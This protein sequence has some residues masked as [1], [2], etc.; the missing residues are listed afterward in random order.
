MKGSIAC[1]PFGPRAHGK[2]MQNR[3]IPPDRM[4]PAKR[5]LAYG[6][7]CIAAAC[8]APSDETN[9]DSPPE[10]P[11][12]V[13]AQAS[14]LGNP[15]ANRVSATPVNAAAAAGATV[16]APVT[17]TGTIAPGPSLATGSDLAWCQALEVMARNCQS[18][19]GAEPQFGAPMPLVS[20]ADL[21]AQS[22]LSDSE[23]VAQRVQERIHSDRNPMPPGGMPAEDL[24]LLDSWLQEGAPPAADLDCG[25]LSGGG[26]FDLEPPAPPEF[27]WPDDCEE[28][29]SLT[30]DV[31]NN[32]PGAYTVAPGAESHPQF[33]FDAPWGND[34]VQIVASRPI[35]DNAKVLHHWILFENGGFAGK[36]LLGWAP[37]KDG[38][39]GLPD[40]VGMYMPGGRSSL[41]L[42]M[43]YY[44]LGSRQ[45]EQ[46][47]S[48]VEVCITRTPRPE[49]A[50][51]V[52]LIGSATAPPGRVDN[53]SRCTVN[54]T[55]TDS[56]KLLSVSPHMHQLGVH[57]KLELTR[58][59]EKTALHDAPF[60]FE[61]QQVFPLESVEVR[62]GDVLTTTCS[63]ENDSGRTVRFGNNSDDEMCFNF[64]TYYPMGS[65]RCGFAL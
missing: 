32:R 31:S 62:T 56:V 49:T 10:A 52:G 50:T 65:F 58:R 47:K 28:I 53:V 19:H 22:V 1:N 44:N 5:R 11:A 23:T 8:S 51:V 30:T 13:P 6:F 26:E 34:P 15:Q 41:R 25:A 29:Y 21:E 12:L 38:N 4:S 59:G 3:N 36:F 17:E 2:G 39:R 54:V 57:A 35:V 45:P 40:N 27:A 37:G 61:D 43:H 20:Y 33:I 42:D 16:S 18:C 48:G 63:Y 7:L 60:S 24:A 14:P 64:V 46:D 9:Q 55:G